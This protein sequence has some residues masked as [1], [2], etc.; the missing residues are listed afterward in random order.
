MKKNS[1]L[2]FLSTIGHLTSAQVSRGTNYFKHTRFMLL[3]EIGKTP[4]VADQNDVKQ[5]YTYF[6]FAGFVVEPRYN[7]VSYADKASISFSVPLTA[8]VM[9]SD[10]IGDG[11]AGVFG[12][13]LFGDYNIGNNATYNNIEKTGFS[14]G[15]GLDIDK[16]IPADIKTMISPKV[17]IGINSVINSVNNQKVLVM[18]KLGIPQPYETSDGEQSLANLNFGASLAFRY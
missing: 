5:S 12:I 16:S 14:F 10:E 4:L 8:R 9:I 15:L 6:T 18:I 17:R 11:G 13:G 3:S 1:L 2:L 7:V